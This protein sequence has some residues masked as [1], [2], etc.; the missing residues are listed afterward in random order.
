MSLFKS[1]ITKGMKT[2]I[3]KEHILKQ[4]NGITFQQNVPVDHHVFFDKPII[5]IFDISDVDRDIIFTFFESLNFSV[6]EF[7]EE[8]WARLNYY[9]IYQEDTLDSILVLSIRYFRK[10]WP[11]DPQFSLTLNSLIA[12]IAKILNKNVFLNIDNIASKDK[13]F[14][15]STCISILNSLSISPLFLPQDMLSKL[16]D[17]GIYKWGDIIELIECEILKRD[18]FS[19]RSLDLFTILESFYPYAEKMQNIMK[20]LVHGNSVPSLESIITNWV[21]KRA[22]NVRD[23]QVI[24]DRMGWSG[25]EYQTLEYVGQ[26]HGLTRERVRQIEKKYMQKLKHHKSLNELYHLWVIIDSLL[27]ESGGILSLSEMTKKLQLLFKSVRPFSERGLDNIFIFAPKKLFQQEIIDANKIILSINFACRN[28]DK[29]VKHFIESILSRDEER[30]DEASDILSDF[31]RTK[32]QSGNKPHLNLSASFVEYAISNSEQLKRII[33]QKDGRL[34]SINRWNLLYGSLLLVAESILRRNKRAMHFTEIYEEIKTSRPSD[35][36]L[37]ARNIH[38]ALDRSHN[39]LLWDRGTFIHKENAAFHYGIIR[40]IEKWV[41]EKLRQ[42]V[43]FISVHGAFE[44]FKEECIEAGVPSESALYSCLRL[45][46]DQ[47]FSYPRYPY[48]YLN[49]DDIQKIPITKAME[50][51]IR[52]AEGA[53]ALNTLKHYA[54]ENLCIQDYAFNQHLARIPDVFR[55]KNGYIHVDYLNIEK[56]RLSEI[57]SYTRNLISKTKHVSAVKIFNDTRVACSLMGVDSPELL[58]SILQLYASSRLEV[59]NYPQIRSISY[60][61][62]KRKSILDDIAEYIRKKKSFCT[63]QELQ[64]HFVEGLGY[65]EQMVYLVGF[66]EGVYQYLDQCLVHTET[67]MWNDEKQKQ[68][69]NIATQAFEDEIKAG[70]CYGSIELITELS[71]LPELGNDLY[72]TEVLVADMLI[73][74]NNFKILGNKKNVYV[75]T[76]NSL[77]VESFED[78]ICEIL[79]REHSGA[80]SLDLFSEK[81]VDL[82]IIAH[83]VTQ[84]MLGNSDK[85]RIV[86]REIILTELINNA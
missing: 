55:T 19:G 8:E 72:W 85:V 75:P 47:L 54:L 83:R 32:C 86:G 30:I 70:R 36:S 46:G 29:V 17:F 23:T 27:Y 73:K 15:D 20:P 81:L 76:S 18:G 49:T 24:T 33:R 14:P 66:K 7:S 57:I 3:K 69:E 64:Q 9:C 77:G 50:E 2:P 5:D 68:I 59:K 48:I 71:D 37:R 41:E 38:A 31:C 35:I 42:A 56:Q 74:G 43:P 21:F 78:L 82:G 44:A 22:K 58:F 45:S 25:N 51:F 52:E 1:G 12:L 63:R 28:C 61:D 4:S 60:V 16:N 13:M 67:I 10:L 65:S 53:V 11:S 39:V 80:E 84:S 40:Q 26:K 79:K 6:L 62:T 34:Y